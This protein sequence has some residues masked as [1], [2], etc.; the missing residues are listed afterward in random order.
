MS[1]I[2][3]SRFSYHAQLVVVFLILG[4]LTQLSG[5]IFPI[6][7]DTPLTCDSSQVGFIDEY[8]QFEMVEGD[9]LVVYQQLTYP[10]CNLDTFDLINLDGYYL[11]SGELPDCESCMEIFSL[12]G[13]ACPL[14]S[15]ATNRDQSLVG[16]EWQLWWL[17]TTDNSYLPPCD[18]GA[19]L[20]IDE[21][22]RLSLKVVNTLGNNLS[23]I[24]NQLIMQNPASSTFILPQ[25]Y[26]GKLEVLIAQSIEEG[27]TLFFEIEQNRLTLTSPDGL[28][29]DWLVVQ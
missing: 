22:G 17:H 25:P 4:L 1:R 28:T 12:E 21:E 11:L 15:R 2:Q 5:C 16:S 24:D 26:P 23:I 7:D 19:T 18:D 29:M 9:T 14:N 10:L 3:I 8:V 6:G 13:P 27:D 20:K